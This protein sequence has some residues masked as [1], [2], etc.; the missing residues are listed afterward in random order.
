MNDEQVAAFAAMETALREFAQ[1]CRATWIAIVDAM[2]PIV[3]AITRIYRQLRAA[4]LI[5]RQYRDTM[6]RRKIRRYMQFCVSRR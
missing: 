5:P 4:H 3:S 6:A 2:T 1:A